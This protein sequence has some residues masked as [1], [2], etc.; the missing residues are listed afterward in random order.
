MS[1]GPHG[2]GGKAS[3]ACQVSGLSLSPEAEATCRRPQGLPRPSCRESR[4]DGDID[5]SLQKRTERCKDWKNNQSSMSPQPKGEG[6]ESDPVP[7]VPTW[8]KRKKARPG[9]RGGAPTPGPVFWTLP[10]LGKTCPRL[11]EKNQASLACGRGSR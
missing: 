7:G 4:V 5:R 1:S 3:T 9:L 11:H 2:S 8:E 10:L 6:G